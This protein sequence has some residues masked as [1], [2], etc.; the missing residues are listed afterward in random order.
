MCQVTP[1]LTLGRGKKKFCD[2]KAKGF[3]NVVTVVTHGF[4]CAP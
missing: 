3:L 1:L 2:G 4:F